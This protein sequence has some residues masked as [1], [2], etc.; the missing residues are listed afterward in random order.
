MLKTREKKAEEKKENNMRRL[1]IEPAISWLKE[2]TG[3]CLYIPPISSIQKS[4]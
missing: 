3:M 1:E 4:N 2:L